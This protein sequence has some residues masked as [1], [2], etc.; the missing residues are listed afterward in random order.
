MPTDRRSSVYFKSLPLPSLTHTRLQKW[1]PHISKTEQNAIQVSVSPPSQRVKPA[2]EKHIDLHSMHDLLILRDRMHTGLDTWAYGHIDL[3]YAHECHPA[4]IMREHQRMREEMTGLQ[5]PIRCYWF[6]ETYPLTSAGV[7]HHIA[8]V[9]ELIGILQEREGQMGRAAMGGGSGGRM[10]RAGR[11]FR[12]LLTQDDKDQS[13]GGEFPCC[14]H[15]ASRPAFKQDGLQKT[16]SRTI[17]LKTES[18]APVGEQD[19]T[20]PGPQDGW[21]LVN[22][23]E[24]GS[25]VSRPGERSG[26][27]QNTKGVDEPHWDICA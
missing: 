25:Y 6:G 13:T 21:Y 1:L 27:V 26:G 4:A 11:V 17:V 15:Q 3:R 23:I 7:M 20:R 9:D 16:G 2:N 8:C 18:P 22:K 24:E 19:V 5:Q 10:S 12:G 14:E